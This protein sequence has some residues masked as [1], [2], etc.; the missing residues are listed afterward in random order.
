MP[1][2]ALPGYLWFQHSDWLSACLADLQLALVD[3]PDGFRVP[4]SSY[5]QLLDDSVAGTVGYWELYI[6]G[7]T[8][9]VGA[10]WAIVCCWTDGNVRQFVGCIAAPVQLNPTSCDWV[11]ASTLDN[12]AAEFSA[13]AWASLIALKWAA[14]STV[15]IRPDLS[16]S[17]LISQGSTAVAT[18]P[19]LA[20]LVRSLG[21]M[22]PPHV[23]VQEV[24]GHR[25]D[26][27][28][29][30]ADGLA[31]HAA[32][33]QGS[34][35]TAECLPLHELAV[36]ELD[37]GWMWLQKDQGLAPAFPRSF[38]GQLWQVG[39][40]TRRLSTHP[41]SV[42]PSPSCR[43]TG[44]GPPA[45]IE[46]KV[47]SINV[48]FLD[49]PLSQSS[50]RRA[51]SGHTARIDTQCH[52]AGLHFVGLQETRTPSGRTSTE[53]YMVFSSGCDDRHTAILGCE[54]WVHRSLP[55]VCLPEGRKL[56]A[57]DFSFV[58]SLK[59][60]VH[61]FRSL[62]ISRFLYNVHV[63][64]GVTEREW[65]RWTAALRLPLLS[66][67]RSRLRLVGRMN[68]PLEVLAGL[69]RL[70]LPDDLVHVARLRYLA[71]LLKVCPPIL[72]AWTA[73]LASTPRSWLTELRSSL[74]W[75][76]RF[77]PHP[78][79]LTA[80]APFAEWFAF[81]SLDASW[82]GRLKTTLAACEGFRHAQAEAHLWNLSFDSVVRQY[83]GVVPDSPSSPPLCSWACDF[84]D[85]RFASKNALAMH[86][87]KVHGYRNITHF[88]AIDG[89][90]PACVR[91]FHTRPRLRS[92]LAASPHCLPVLRACFAPLTDEAVQ[93]LDS[94]DLEAAQ[95][96]QK[97]GWHSTKALLPRAKC[98][99][100][101]LPLP[102]SPEA[103]LMLE[104]SLARSAPG[105]RAFVQ[106][107][108]R[109]CGSIAADEFQ[110]PPSP[111]DDLPPFVLQSAGGSNVADGR[112]AHRN[113][114][115]EYAR[116]HF[117]HFVVVHFFSGFRRDRDIHHIVEQAAV[118][119]GVCVMVLS[120][121]LCMQREAVHADLSTLASTTWW[122]DRVRS[123]Q[124]IAAGGGPPCET[125]TA[126]RM[127][128]G[129][130]RPLRSS[131]YLY[132]CPHL[133][134]REWKQVH[135]GTTLV[136]FILRLA[137]ELAWR[138]GCSWCEH[139]QWP[140][141]AAR[142][143]PPS[144]WAMRAVRLLRQFQCVSVVSFDQCTVGADSVKPTTL[145]LVR[146]PAVRAAL[147]ARGNGGRCHHGRG[148]HRSLIGRTLCGDFNTARGKIYPPPLN[149]VLGLSMIDFVKSID[150]VTDPAFAS[151]GLDI[152]QDLT[153]TIHEDRAVV[154]ADYHG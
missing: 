16:L 64:V 11:G 79:P 70:P 73:Q 98:S 14:S 131:Q 66:L 57:A 95:A 15:V 3:L 50:R 80:D 45:L 100:P 71:R 32:C 153:A 83:G 148:A 47:A 43:P 139:P 20:M 109:Q 39:P 6:D 26:P 82:K 31:R 105:D 134:R 53:H 146:L 91:D 75:L 135:I 127:V 37:C 72:W 138:G 137:L 113:L 9:D 145:L 23:S 107:V 129:G 87:A 97:E 125:Y 118:D 38:G 13:M 18:N 136:H 143:S 120:V 42:L 121:D 67:V 154:Q 123:G 58:V 86:S 27:W 117:K 69:V 93:Q 60:K 115:T 48:L 111:V 133:T 85:A 52:Q 140:L 151:E 63:W 29:D 116:C 49:N 22:F 147:L 92:H 59:H 119:A 68:L 76:L 24:R 94:V 96:L 74:R 40:S 101:A 149:E 150:P 128:E 56:I 30:L 81:V 89:Q 65:N 99:G 7:S 55:L 8:S 12:I 106:M 10:A 114:A 90:C 1:S 104:R 51:R 88:F 78:L 142:S 152:F 84:C 77:Y 41:P 103:A 46:L 122:L 61:I 33:N 102:G 126:A 2:D 35:G 19:R 108:G 54:L 34:V 124:V 130:P 44:A 17:R 112:M 28:N 62:S 141:W 4:V 25:G 36:S 132:G 144:I 5:W 21:G 110:V